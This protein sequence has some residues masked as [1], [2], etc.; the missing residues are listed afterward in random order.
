MRGMLV[1]SSHSYFIDQD[2]NPSNGIIRWMIAHSRLD[3]NDTLIFIPQG[4]KMQIESC[5]PDQQKRLISYEI[6]RFLI[7]P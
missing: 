2:S 6:S 1:H 4:M 3:G 7:F 5:R